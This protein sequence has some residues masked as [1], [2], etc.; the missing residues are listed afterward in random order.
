MLDWLKRTKLPDVWAIKQIDDDLLH[1]CGRGELE[2]RERPAKALQALQE[3]RFEGAIRM[4]DSALV[5]NARLFAALAPVD[6]LILRGQDRAKWCDRQYRLSWVPQRCWVYEGRL[7]ST[8]T[9]VNGVPQHV[10]VEDVSAIRDKAAS[11]ESDEASV[12]F[13]SLEARGNL[14]PLDMGPDRRR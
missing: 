13:A 12:H 7:T 5:L 11:A 14:P 1:V 10:S 8:L 4:H 3:N 2:P 9:H 6:D